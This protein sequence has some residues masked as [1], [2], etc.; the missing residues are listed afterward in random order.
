ME[1]DPNKELLDKLEK[2]KYWGVSS[3][4]EMKAY[5]KKKNQEQKAAGLLDEDNVDTINLHEKPDEETK[6]QRL[7]I[8]A[9]GIAII[10]CI[11]VVAVIACMR[12]A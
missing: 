5:V 6:K 7:R 8:N 11:V 1:K 2:A 4:A 10:T 12:I 3:E 9:W